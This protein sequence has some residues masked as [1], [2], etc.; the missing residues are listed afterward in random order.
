MIPFFDV[1]A[2]FS[3]LVPVATWWCGVVGD[4]YV[5]L[6]PRNEWYILGIRTFGVSHIGMKE[7][8]GW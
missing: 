6:P 4:D 8:S 3:L 1:A 7:K 5:L 2:A